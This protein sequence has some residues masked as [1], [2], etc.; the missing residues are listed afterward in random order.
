V[1]VPVPVDQFAKGSPTEP[2]PSVD[3]VIDGQGHARGLG[4]GKEGLVAGPPL[5]YTAC[6]ER[7]ATAMPTEFEPVIGLEVHAQ[8]LTRSKIFCSCSTAGGLP[9][10]HVCPVCL[11]LP[12]ALPVL[13]REAV[14]MA[15]RAGLALGC[16]IREKSRFA[17]KNYFYPDLPKGY[18]ISQYDEPLCEYGALTVPLP[19]GRTTR[20][21]IRRIHMEEDA[22]K[23]VHGTVVGDASLVDLNRA[24]VPLIEIVS[25]PDL[26]SSVEAA[27]Y[28]RQLRAVLMAL[29]VNDGNLE[30]G[31]FRCDV[32]VSVRPKGAETY[33]TRV[34]IKN[35]NSFRFVQRAIEYEV[36]EQVAKVSSGIAVRQ[37]TK[38]WNEAAGKTIE[39]REK[40]N[41]D[42]YRYFPEP[43]LPPL[44]V[45]HEWVERVRAEHPELPAAKRERYV[46]T[47]GIDP[48]AA[49]V[50]TEH[51]ALSAWF[52][53]AHALAGGD[54]KRV[55]NFLVNEVKRDVVYEGLSAR[56]P[57]EPAA[58][59]ELLALVDAGTISGKIAKDVYADMAQSGRGAAAIV[60][61]KGLTVVTDT[62][63]IE[64]AVRQVLDA[65]PK[66]ADSYRGGKTALF[67]FFVGQVMKATQGRA[68]PE[69][70]NETLKRMLG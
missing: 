29:G 37:F 64:A 65:N 7:L 19:D 60:K 39:L 66:Q 5:L 50:L 28:L 15:L 53:K 45:S 25:D 22:G 52:E 42:D 54:A 6:N 16:T 31:S 70:V 33:G 62:G 2:Q 20:V 47:L 13:N 40:G 41:A 46:K 36:A 4:L 32:N 51:P 67:G 11:G 34:E 63:A 38:Q 59:A 9:N 10:T 26:R 68:S 8:L 69:L 49:D 55:A 43:D 23:N 56:F 12:G 3:A 58:L 1:G 44:E 57:I 21:G 35:V 14:E 27:E 48:K 24:G 61:D 17:R 18:Q 30:E